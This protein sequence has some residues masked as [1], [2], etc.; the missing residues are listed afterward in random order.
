MGACASSDS[1]EDASAERSEA[2]MEGNTPFPVETEQSADFVRV[3]PNCTS[4][5]FPVRRRSSQNSTLDNKDRLERQRNSL[6]SLERSRKSIT[7]HSTVDAAWSTSPSH[8]SPCLTTRPSITSSVEGQATS[9]EH[10]EQNQ[11][12]PR[13]PSDGNI[14][15]MAIV[16]SGQSDA[17]HRTSCDVRPRRILKQPRNVLVPLSHLDIGSDKSDFSDEEDVTVVQNEDELV[18]SRKGTSAFFVEVT[19]RE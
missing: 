19:P 8:C 7:F 2:P 10:P 13:K 16:S 4:G 3:N 15:T 18:F 6:G 14:A 1:V 12:I 9:F 11:E 5:G 17:P